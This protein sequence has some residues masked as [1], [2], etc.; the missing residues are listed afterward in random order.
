[1]AEIGEKLQY[2]LINRRSWRKGGTRYNARGLDDRG[3]VAN[4]VETEQLV[5][6]KGFACS[7]VQIRG[8]VPAF[9][10]QEG[11]TAKVEFTR[12]YTYS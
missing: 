11:I 10:K 8:S 4:F 6:Y 3:N 9:W 1:M 7:H 5:Y 12:E 2:Y